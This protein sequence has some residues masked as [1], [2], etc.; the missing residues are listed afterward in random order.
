MK[1]YHNQQ[2]K[3]KSQISKLIGYDV[4]NIGWDEAFERATIGG[5]MGQKQLQEVVC[6][7]CKQLDPFIPDSLPKLD[8]VNEMVTIFNPLAKDFNVSFDIMGTG[9]PMNFVV[10]AKD[11][12]KFDPKVANHIKTHLINRIF[13]ERGINNPMES[14]IEKIN[15]EV[16]A[17]L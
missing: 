5:K 16:S 3:L 7:L 12:G 14:D 2:M 1:V 10:R 17:Q 6:M 8:S 9:S 11:I 4:E 13:Q 15:K